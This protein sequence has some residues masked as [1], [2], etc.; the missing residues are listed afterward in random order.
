MGK[1]IIVY[2]AVLIGTYLL[3][4]NATKAGTLIT[5]LSGGA[6]GYAKTLQGR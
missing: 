5:S 2:S 3:V 4:A 6:S 1:K